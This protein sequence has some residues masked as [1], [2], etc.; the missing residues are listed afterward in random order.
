MESIAEN[1]FVAT[2]SWSGLHDR[3]KQLRVDRLK[4][5]QAPEARVH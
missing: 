5:G 4:E 3:W 1:V 2:V